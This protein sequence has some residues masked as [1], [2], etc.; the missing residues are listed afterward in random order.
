LQRKINRLI[1]DS[2]IRGR[3]LNRTFERFEIDEYNQ[4]AYAA[5][6]RYADTFPAML[7]KS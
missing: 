7:P 2:G 4:R 1:K 6:K 3:F 5:A